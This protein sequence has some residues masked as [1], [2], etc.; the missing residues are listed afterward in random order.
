MGENA[1][2]M[3]LTIG[4]HSGSFH[5]DDVLAVALVR[6]FVDAAARIV[7]SR[8]LDELARCDVVVDVGGRFDAEA[9]RFDHHQADYDGP[10]SSAGM[11][12][13]WLERDGDVS[14]EL[15]ARLRFE[16]VDYVD[17]V[18]NGR[19]QPDPRVPCL[20]SI[21]GS[22]T[23]D[24]GD[25]SDFD[26]R[27]EIAVAFVAHYVRGIRAGVEQTSRAAHAVRTAMDD[28]R[29][30]GRR[31]LF[32]H[33]YLPWKAAYFEHGG[34]QHPTDFVLFPAEG[35]WRIYAIPPAPGSF[36]QKLPLP[37]AWAGLTDSDLEAVTGVAGARFCHKNR[38]VAVFATRD[39]A[40]HALRNAFG[41]AWA[42]GVA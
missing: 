22:L 19:R 23:N 30:A 1:L 13:A 25:G 12:L 38:F 7:R 11:V 5:A 9:R 8:D 24:P 10:L 2:Q 36:A 42:D 35:S 26:A 6:V 33:D 29:A 20:P 3:G 32:L 15:A 4:T 27:F 21:V 37:A 31:T 18:D 16:L 39:G 14:A 40:L 34:A 28:A 41:R 17:D